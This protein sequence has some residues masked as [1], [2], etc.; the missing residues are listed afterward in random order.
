ML[1]PAV[2]LRETETAQSGCWWTYRLF[3]FFRTRQCSREL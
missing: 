3:S 1:N 2:V